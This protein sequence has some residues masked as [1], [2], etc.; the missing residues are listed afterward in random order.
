MFSQQSYFDAL[1][2]CRRLQETLGPVAR[3]E[4]HLFAYL[5][6]L[7]ALY[8]SQPVSEWGYYFAV[9]PDGYPYSPDLD[10]ALDILISSGDLQTDRD[11]YL[12]MSDYGA[13]TLRELNT[14][15]LFQPR[16]SF[17]EGACSSVLALPVGSIRDALSQEV[18][19]RNALALSQS[20]RLPT[21]VGLNLLYAQF[22]ALSEAI[23]VNVDDLLIPAVVWLTYL[24]KTAS[25]SLAE[26]ER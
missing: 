11:G 9:T 15:G 17:L 3:A 8:R 5:S 22:R 18:G 10:A 19:I 14:L 4:V 2:V 24:I 25:T 1:D 13:E 23:G 6:C 26:T 16:T 12:A 20:R 21:D 7:L